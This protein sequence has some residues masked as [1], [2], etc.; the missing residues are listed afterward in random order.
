M[1]R[2][3]TTSTGTR[4]A[5]A[6]AAP[7]SQP[8]RARIQTLDD[9]QRDP[10]NANR[11]TD[12]CR[13][14]LRRSLEDYGAGRSIVVDARGRILGGDKTVE[15]A[16][17][18]GLPI[19]VVPTD[20]QRLIVVQRVDL[21]AQ[22]DPR[23][24][25]LA[26]AD[27][28]VGELDLDWN[29]AVLQQLEQAGV[30]LDGFWTPEEFAQ[31]IRPT[32]PGEDPNENAVLAPPTATDIRLGDVF[33]LGRHR[34]ACGD[35]TVAAD[36]KRLL[37]GAQPVLMAVDPPYGVD[38]EPGFRHK[39]YPRQRTAVGR[40]ANDTQAD[41]AAA[42][43]LFPGDIIYTWHAALFADV[44]LAGLRQAGF[45][46]RYQIIWSKPTFVLGRGAYHW[47]HETA[48]FAVRRGRPAPWYGGRGQSTVWKVPNLN[49][50]GGSRTGENTPTGH[51]TQ[52]PVRVFEIPILN[53]N[54][55]IFE[56]RKRETAA[57]GA[58]EKLVLGHPLAAT[59][60]DS[61]R[62]MQN[63]EKVL[64]T[65]PKTSDTVTFICD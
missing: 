13:D 3:R 56:A 31:L 65:G 48:W 44:V 1:S 5:R 22:T 47:Q 63:L 40:V 38:Y 14:A 4:Q 42:Y 39:A 50:I 28:R 23:A 26:V 64:F 58:G 12:R 54:R 34:L 16:K 51:A 36:V 43:A 21:D 45:E 62:C 25:A 24:Q 46:A 59:I 49:A 35:A 53:P 6:R 60:G 10:L 17:E 27:N 55:K 15:Q 18:L 8:R 11:G 29:P 9:L 41:W 57:L 7:V 33:Q 30:A 52:K 32:Q 61:A 20:G 2:S 19:T 37:A